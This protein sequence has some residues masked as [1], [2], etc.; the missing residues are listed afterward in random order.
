MGQFEHGVI[1]FFA[2]TDEGQRELAVGV[3]I[4]AQQFH[5]QHLGIEIDGT[6]QI[7]HTQHRMQHSHLATP[8]G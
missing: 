1:A 8:Y 5:A 3:V 2:V 7:S 6:I 4:P